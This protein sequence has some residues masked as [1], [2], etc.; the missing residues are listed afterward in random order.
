MTKYL[1]SFPS[2]A[3]V[4]PEED[5]QTVSDESHAV[6]EE[7][8]AAGVYVFAGGINE[9]VAPVRVSADGSVVEA[10]TSRPAAS[11]A[12]T[13]SSNYPRGRRP[14]NGPR[15][16]RRRADAIRNFASS[17][18]THSPDAGDA[19]GGAC[20]FVALEG[21]TRRRCPGSSTPSSARAARA[22]SAGIRPRWDR[23]GL[24]GI[25]RDEEVAGRFMSRLRRA[26]KTH[27]LRDRRSTL[28]K[29]HARLFKT[30]LRRSTRVGE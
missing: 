24:L 25:D 3:M 16:S 22:R 23:E 17:C 7:A 14:R 11:R 9:N 15:R 4:F 21:M 5:F 28:A 29:L 19:Q 18:T 26:P 12:A 30:D 13:R 27:V 20:M 6:V 8:K 1:I 2:S 10:S